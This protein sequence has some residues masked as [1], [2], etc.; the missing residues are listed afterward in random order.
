MQNMRS[1]Q[2]ASGEAGDNLTPGGAKKVQ[3]WFQ[4]CASGKNIRKNI[5]VIMQAQAGAEAKCWWFLECFPVAYDPGDYSPS[6]TGVETIVVQAERAELTVLSVE[7]T[8]RVLSADGTGNLY[9]E[10]RIKPI[11]LEL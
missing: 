4:K 7:E 10:V 6:S 8:E 11:R 3:Q 9:E 1:A 2:V 5:S